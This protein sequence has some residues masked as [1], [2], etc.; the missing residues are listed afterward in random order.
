MKISYESSELIAELKQDIAE[1]GNI[2]M[3]A[4]VKEI[5]GRQFITNYD[6]IEEEQPL[7]GNEFDENETILVLK[8]EKILELLEEQNRII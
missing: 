7:Q 5:Y 2:D 1:F 3:Y 6:F 8:A 4:W